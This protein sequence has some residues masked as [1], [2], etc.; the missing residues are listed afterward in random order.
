MD[1]LPDL[2]DKLDTIFGKQRDEL[3]RRFVREREILTAQQAALLEIFSWCE[4]P[5]EH[6][7]LVAFLHRLTERGNSYEAIEATVPYINCPHYDVPVTGPINLR[8]YPQ[9]AIE[10]AR[11]PSKHRPEG[12]PVYMRADFLF[13]LVCLGDAELRPKAIVV[14]I[15][16]HE[17]HERTQEQA[18]R[19]RSRDRFLTA[20]RTPFLRYTGREINANPANAVD[21]VWRFLKKLFGEMLKESLTRPTPA[22]SR[23]RLLETRKTRP[24]GGLAQTESEE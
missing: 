18:R 15:D 13:E 6:Y 3:E 11:K 20:S 16:G 12:I 22:A 9:R 14:E 21:E 23:L 17:F 5:L 7:V 4:S 19:D 1:L 24:V 2:T 10:R 8:I